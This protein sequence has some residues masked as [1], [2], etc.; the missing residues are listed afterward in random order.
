MSPCPLRLSSRTIFSRK[1]GFISGERGTPSFMLFHFLPKLP[2]ML[3][4]VCMSSHPAGLRAWLVTLSSYF[5]YL[6][7]PR[8]QR[9]LNTRMLFASLTSDCVHQGPYM[10]ADQTTIPCL[11]YVLGLYLRSERIGTLHPFTWLRR[12]SESSMCRGSLGTQTV[13]SRGALRTS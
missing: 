10:S 5:K 3:L 11:H 12:T 7:V 2:T 9:L 13:I 6:S 4:D 8:I 1:P